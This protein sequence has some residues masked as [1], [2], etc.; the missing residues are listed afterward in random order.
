MNTRWRIT[1]GKSARFQR[2][3]ENNKCV[4]IDFTV[5]KV[6]RVKKIPRSYRVSANEGI[7][8]EP[9]MGRVTRTKLSCLLLRFSFPT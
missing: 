1:S 7:S 4:L 6:R 3:I 9:M 2:Y 5:N 8:N